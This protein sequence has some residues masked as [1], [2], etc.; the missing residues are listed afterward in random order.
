MKKLL[1]PNDDNP[2]EF[3]ETIEFL[4]TTKLAIENVE[5]DNYDFEEYEDLPRHYWGGENGD[6][7]IFY[8]DENQEL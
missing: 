5:E 8:D 4:K 2:A 3:D 7:I 6:E 1:E